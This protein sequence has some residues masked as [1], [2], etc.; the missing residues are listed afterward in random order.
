MATTFGP[1]GSANAV[2]V[3]ADGKLAV[4]GG[5]GYSL[6]PHG[7]LDN[8][9]F[10]L[11]RYNAD[12]NLDPGFG[13]GGTVAGMILGSAVALAVQVDGKLVAAG[14][15]LETGFVLARYYADGSLD[16]SFGTGGTVTTGVSGAAF[17]LAVQADGKLVAAGDNY[18]T[19]STTAVFAL[20]RYESRTCATLAACR[21]SLKTTLPKPARVRGKRSK[22]TARK[23]QRLRAKTG[24]ALAQQRYRK[25]REALVALLTAAQ[26]AEVAGTLGVPLGPLQA[27]VTA[28]L[29]RIPPA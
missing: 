22:E 10:T 20:A 7:S 11:A 23:L 25:A 19:S 16:P 15:G 8:F 5:L 3:Q 18:S 12:G 9:K 26:G 27:A 17:G 13:T 6:G 29:A 4:A 1:Q 28:L 2:R 14:G 21:V 24:R